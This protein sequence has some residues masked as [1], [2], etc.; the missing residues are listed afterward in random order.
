MD[1]DINAVSWML[2]LVPYSLGYTLGNVHSTII[3][4]RAVGEAK[5]HTFSTCCRKTTIDIGTK[6]RNG[7]FGGVFSRSTDRTCYCARPGARLW[8]ADLS[9]NVLAT[10]NFKQSLTQ[11]SP[12]KIKFLDK[13]LNTENVTGSISAFPHL[14]IIR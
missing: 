1:L 7:Q 9:G 13:S 6:P 2:H 4:H 10:H 5:L 8:K 14:S 3:S 11:M 12:C